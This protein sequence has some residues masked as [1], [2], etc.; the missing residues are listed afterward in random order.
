[1]V[2]DSGLNVFSTKF[3]LMK[4]NRILL[5]AKKSS[6]KYLISMDKDHIDSKHITFMG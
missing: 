4:D 1:M 6:H 5:A 3:Y 2:N